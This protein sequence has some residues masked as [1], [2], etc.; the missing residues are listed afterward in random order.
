MRGRPAMDGDVHVSAN[1]YHYTKVDGRWRLTHHIIA[2]EYI[3]KRPLM[4]HESVVFKDKRNKLD[5]RPENIE[6]R[7]KGKTTLRKR[8][9]QLEARIEELQAQLAAVNRELEDSAKVST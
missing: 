7:V 1:G 8:R 6:V 5:L 2:E 4:E 3:L 9:A